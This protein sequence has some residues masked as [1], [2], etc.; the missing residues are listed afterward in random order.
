MMGESGG[1]RQ[2]ESVTDPARVESLV[3]SRL[4][5]QEEDED[6]DKNDGVDNLCPTDAE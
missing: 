4:I 6:T 1:A 5:D 2:L 3:G